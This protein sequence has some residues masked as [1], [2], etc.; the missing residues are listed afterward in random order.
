MQQWCGQLQFQSLWFPIFVLMDNVEKH[1]FL[2]LF[3]KTG[4]DGQEMGERERKRTAAAVKFLHVAYALP[5]ELSGALQNNIL[6]E[7]HYD[8]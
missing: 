7:I 6:T 8:T 3:E 2:A 1:V 4:E 5:G